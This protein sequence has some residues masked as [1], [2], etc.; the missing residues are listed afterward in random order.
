MFKKTRLICLIFSFFLFLEWSYGQVVD[1]AQLSKYPVFNS[2]AAADTMPVENVLR[3]SL[4]RKLPTDFNE[5]ILKYN[6]LQ[7][8]HLKNMRL[9][10]IPP[11][12]WSLVNLTVLDVSNNK[13]NNL[14][15]HLGELIYLERLIINRNNISALPKQ[16][17][18]LTHLRYIDMF[19]TLITDF[20][21][22]ISALQ[23]SLKEIDMRVVQLND[24][25][26]ERL[27]NYLPNTKFW[28]SYSCNCKN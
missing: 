20:P 9:K 28:F 22:E 6:H 7:E 19:S 11:S 15:D 5:K 16:I 14:S 12:V 23:D 1:S 4:K 27:Q 26:K 18:Q 10:E 8:L 21:A 25:Q 24:Y 13:L 17:T 2:F 3:L